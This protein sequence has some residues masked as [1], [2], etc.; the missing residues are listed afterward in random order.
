MASISSSLTGYCPASFRSTDSFARSQASAFTWLGRSGSDSSP[1]PS[2]A[3][4]ALARRGSGS[5]RSR[6]ASSA[7]R[8]GYL[9]HNLNPDYDAGET[10][11][12]DVVDAL[13]R[14]DDGASYRF[15]AG[16]DGI[17]N[18]TRQTLSTIYQDEERR[19]WYLKAVADDDRVDEALQEVAVE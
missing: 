15:V 1:G 13:E 17:P 9:K 7:V 11:F 6:R 14:L 16:D 2:A 3:S 8:R 18:V 4:N 19:Q 12:F 5:V 10:G